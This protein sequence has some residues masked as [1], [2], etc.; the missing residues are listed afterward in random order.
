[1]PSQAANLVELYDFEG[2]FEVAAQ[3]VLAAAGIT[4]AISQAAAQLPL[5]TTGISFDVQ[6]AT[7][8]L[9]LLATPPGWPANTPP[10]QEYFR[11]TATLEFR[12]EVPRDRNTPTIP[13]VQTLF[14]EFRGKVRAYFGRIAAPF[15]ET[16]LPYYEIGDIK[17]AGA[18]TGF[19]GVRNIDFCAI[20]FA[21][22]FAIRPTAWPTWP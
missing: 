18:F 19:E 6:L 11:Y 17:P 16:N 15:D 13:Q 9:A 10:P 1:M 14:S 2:Q 5:V 7:G 4:A 22:T 3:G 12:V 8:D 20:R 21:V